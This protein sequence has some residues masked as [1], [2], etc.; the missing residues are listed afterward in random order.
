LILTY[1]SIPPFLCLSVSLS[2]S[3]SSPSSFTLFYSV[4]LV[5]S[6]IFLYH[7][8][9]FQKTKLTIFIIT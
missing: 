6:I 4:Y 2:L 3:F 8:T 1:H 7:F 9:I 5:S